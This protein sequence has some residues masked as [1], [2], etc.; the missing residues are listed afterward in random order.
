M[1]VAHGCRPDDT[2]WEGGTFFLRIEFSESYPSVVPNIK[3]TNHLFHPNSGRSLVGL[4]SS[5]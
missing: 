4:I 3:F 2:P 5:I 1:L